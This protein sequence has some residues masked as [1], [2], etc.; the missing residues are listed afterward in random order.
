MPW[1]G[2]TYYSDDGAKERMGS[3]ICL[4]IGGPLE[5]R[6]TRIFLVLRKKEACY[7]S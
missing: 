6:R 1:S 7:S 2:D 4:Y 3:K 5:K